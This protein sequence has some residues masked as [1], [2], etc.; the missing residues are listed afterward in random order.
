[1][2][3]GVL[4]LVGVILVGTTALA[5]ASPGAARRGRVVRVERP[6]GATV[7]RLC[8][9]QPTAKTALCVGQPAVGERVALID[10]ERG[11]AVGEFRIETT[12]PATE[13]WLCPGASA[14]VYKVSGTIAEGDRATVANASR[15]IGLRNLELDPR[16][17]AVVKDPPVPPTAERAELAL[18]FTGNGSVDFM[19]VRYTCDDQ[20]NPT[21]SSDRRV[22]FDSYLERAG[23]LERAHQD[24]I[25]LCF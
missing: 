17:A 6:R 9:V 14:S 24:I 3:V 16:K 19:L 1:M 8:D 21:A 18:D 22:C 5:M 11:V 7:P 25:Q 15:I 4:R 12:A 23:R 10:Q 2:L 13:P 20:G